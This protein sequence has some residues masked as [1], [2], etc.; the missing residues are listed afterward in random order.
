M[1]KRFIPMDFSPFKYSF[2]DNADWGAENIVHYM[3]EYIITT[4]GKLK[5]KNAQQIN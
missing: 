1:L 4:E 5:L 3:F 2:V